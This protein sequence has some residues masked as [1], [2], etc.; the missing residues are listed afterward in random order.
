[1]FE[2]HWRN[3]IL[4][5]LDFEK[6]D[7]RPLEDYTV[8]MYERFVVVLDNEKIYN[9]VISPR[10]EKSPGRGPGEHIMRKSDIGAGAGYIF[11]GV[12]G[13]ILYDGWWNKYLKAEGDGTKYGF[14]RE[15]SFEGTWTNGKL[16]GR[17]KKFYTKSLFMSAG[18]SYIGDWVH[19][20]KNGYGIKFYNSGTIMYKGLW[21]DG[22]W[23]GFG[24]YYSKTGL[25]TVH[26]SVWSNT[27]CPRFEDRLDASYTTEDLHKCFDDDAEDD[28]EETESCQDLSSSDDS[29]S[30]SD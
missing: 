24:E 25:K 3:D 2:G 5:D 18:V 11:D 26:S 12:T 13:G 30:D 17:G 9:R 22:Q 21:K 16:N 14:G 4:I 1:M 10:K 8:F 23:S 20:K 15:P 28:S 6:K 27:L 29:H 19:G 7:L